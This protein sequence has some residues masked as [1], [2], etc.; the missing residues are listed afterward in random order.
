MSNVL[1]DSCFWIALYDGGDSQSE[2][3][4]EIAEL[5]DNENIIVPFPTLYEF[6]NSRLSRR[7]SKIQFELFLK[8]PNVKLLSDEKY[9][10]EALESFF[11]KSKF[12]YTDISLVD[13][14]LN[15]IVEDVDVKID[16]IVS[17][18]QGLINSAISKGIKSL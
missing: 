12:S 6:V 18:D 1:I 15:L 4:E 10:Y 14:V 17:F 13:E 8:R 11:Q 9:K 7:E 16:Y 3:A 2:K 5:I